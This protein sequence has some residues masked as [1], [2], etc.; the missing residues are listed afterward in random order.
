MLIHILMNNNKDTIIESMKID[1]I[2]VLKMNNVG[3]IIFK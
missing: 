2:R 3:S 1:Y